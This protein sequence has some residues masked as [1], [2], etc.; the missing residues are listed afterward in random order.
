MNLLGDEENNDPTDTKG[1][2]ENIEANKVVMVKRK[3]L[4]W[5]D[6]VVNEDN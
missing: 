1:T 3:V 6:K 5:P 4:L 2:T